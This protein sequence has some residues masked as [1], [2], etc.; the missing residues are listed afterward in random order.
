MEM[1]CA[2]CIEEHLPLGL[3]QNI[4]ERKMS[5]ELVEETKKQIW[6]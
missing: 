6:K 5:R 3:P 1:Q 4:S 2:C